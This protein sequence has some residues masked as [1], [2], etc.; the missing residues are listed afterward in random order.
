MLFGTPLAI[1]PSATHLFKRYSS[2]NLIDSHCK[3]VLDTLD[4]T[5]DAQVLGCLPAQ[6]SDRLS[7]T[8]RQVL[9]H[10]LELVA[11]IAIVAFLAPLGLQQV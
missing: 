4:L 2:V 10:A 7:Y 1:R 5:S 8:Y 6:H 11:H 9:P 3:V